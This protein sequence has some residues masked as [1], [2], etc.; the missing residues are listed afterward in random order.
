MYIDTHTHSDFSYDADYPLE[1][2]IKAAE[3]AGLSVLAVTDHCDIERL[4]IDHLY[5]SMP[6]AA[7]TLLQFRGSTNLTL[8]CGIEVGEFCWNIPAVRRILS[9][10]PYDMVIGSVHVLHGGDDFYVLDYST[11]DDNALF[12]LFSRSYNEALDLARFGEF[13]TFAHLIYPYRYFNLYERGGMAFAEQFDKQANELFHILAESGKAFEFNTASYSRGGA[14][15]AL[16]LRY[17]SMF[18]EAGGEYVTVGS[19]AHF[20]EHVG[21]YMKEAY[22]ALKAAGFCT[23]TYFKERTPVQ[24]PLC[25]D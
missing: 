2:M 6:K 23:V 17:L 12:D 25:T 7:Q 8:L 15:L 3:D 18:R 10:S 5:E 21:R 13:D 20:P 16:Y 19:D 4:H 24:I 9:A 22:F 14:E 11:L 1:V